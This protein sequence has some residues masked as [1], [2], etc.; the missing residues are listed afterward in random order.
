MLSLL[1]TTSRKPRSE[2][3]AAAEEWAKRLD[4]SFVPREDRSL[5]TIA[6]DEN[7]RGVLVIGDPEPTYYEPARGLEYLFH[8]NMAK[9]RIHNLKSG[10][11]D[12]MVT[13][14][15]LDEGDEVLDCTLGRGADAIVASWVVGPG[16]RV[17]GIEKVPVI[18]QLTIHGLR[19]YEITPADVTEALRRVEAHQADYRDYL[20]ECP[21]D[22][23]DIVYFDPIF[24][25]PL[26]RSQ[27]MELL[28]VLGDDEPVNA[29]AIVQALRAARRGVVIKQRVGSG[30]WDELPCC[31]QLV[32]GTSS[33]I[34][35]G[36]LRK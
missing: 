13:A 31:I 23:F 9:V 33:R 30:L 15:S 6:V 2:L 4:T 32:S 14:M 5:A 36:V 28:R 3:R 35:Y 12:P 8:P 10:R 29:E 22:S 16:G 18:A 26:E 34:E 24:D 27:A 1:V 20:P 19:N 25:E 21:A 17:V 7:V 11:G